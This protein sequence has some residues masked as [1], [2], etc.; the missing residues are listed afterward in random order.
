MTNKSDSLRSSRQIRRP[1]GCHDAELTLHQLTVTLILCQLNQGFP[2]GGLW[3]ICCVRASTLSCLQVITGR[4]SEGKTFF[5]FFQKKAAPWLSAEI[6][7]CQVLRETDAVMCFCVYR[8]NRITASFIIYPVIVW[9]YIIHPV[10]LTLRYRA[11]PASLCPCLPGSG[12]A[13]PL[14]RRRRN[15]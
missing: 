13:A 6:D 8:R 4:F 10:L 3:V 11:L 14:A 2:C 1:G 12:V 15:V 9:H 7:V 5:F